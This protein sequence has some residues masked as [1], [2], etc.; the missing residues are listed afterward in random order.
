MSVIANSTSESLSDERPVAAAQARAAL[1][2][3]HAL[4]SEGAPTHRL[5]LPP[6][7]EEQPFLREPLTRD[8]EGGWRDDINQSSKPKAAADL[9]TE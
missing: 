8:S 3:M 2:A 6:I 9:L 4:R 5:K 1:Q 7:A